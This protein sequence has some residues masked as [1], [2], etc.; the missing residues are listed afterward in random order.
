[1]RAY[2]NVER[3]MELVLETTLEMKNFTNN[4]ITDII[5]NN[6]YFLSKG[7]GVNSLLDQIPSYE[8]SDFVNSWNNLDLD[9]Y[10]SDGGTYRYRRHAVFTCGKYTRNIVQLDNYPHYQSRQYN[11]LNGGVE[12]WYKSIEK[13][14]IES[15]AFGILIEHALNIFNSCEINQLD[16]WPSW[17]IEA[18]QFRIIANGIMEG[19]PT[20]EG[21]HKDG[22]SYIF[23]LPVYIENVDGGVSTFYSNDLIPLDV[24]EMSV[25]DFAYVDD[26]KVYHGVSEVKPI[27][28]SQESIRDMLVITFKKTN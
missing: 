27:N 1:M 10:M 9:N 12:R 7:N 22:V 28:D 18:H 3:P 2:F 13:N 26:S 21:I 25:G 15:N 24:T 16:N 23:M 20:P 19:R 11:N 14:T 17:Y 6:G 8:W 5:L 4:Q